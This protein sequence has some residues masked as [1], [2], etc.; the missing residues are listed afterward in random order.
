MREIAIMKKLHHLNIIG[1]HEVIDDDEEDKLYMVIEFAENGQILDWDV[2]T[3]RFYCPMNRERE[4]TEDE[5]RGLLR[6]A[7]SGLDYLHTRGIIHR[8]IK[9][10]NILLSAQN[11]VKI[12][13][14]GQ[15]LMFENDDIISKSV[16]TY[17]FFPP[18]CCMG[19]VDSAGFS[20]RAADIW[21]WV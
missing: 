15:A 1:L 7:L 19:S 17:H 16:G 20:G 13:D 8:D 21:Q 3:R 18:E 5:I 12:A 10:Q 14:F 2:D 6:D 9:P 11:E 4:Y